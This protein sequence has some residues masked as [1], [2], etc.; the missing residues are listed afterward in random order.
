MYKIT[1]N[2]VDHIKKI[3]RNDIRNIFKCTEKSFNEILKL[4]IH[5]KIYQILKIMQK[6][7][8]SQ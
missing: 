5:F 7:F 6:N 8:Q 4:S 2:K 3:N 1:N